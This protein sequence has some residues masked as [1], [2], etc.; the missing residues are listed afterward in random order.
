MSW[1]S[2]VVEWWQELDEDVFAAIIVL[3]ALLVMVPVILL[4]LK[5]VQFWCN[6]INP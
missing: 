5:Y 2:R 1:K 4:W 6:I 3:I